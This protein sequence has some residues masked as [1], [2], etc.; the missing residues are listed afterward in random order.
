MTDHDETNQMAEDLALAARR[1]TSA[2]TS[3]RDLS[4]AVERATQSISRVGVCFVTKRTLDAIVEL[5]RLRTLRTQ[6]KLKGRPG[7]KQLTLRRARR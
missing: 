3:I 4:I 5:Q 6:L 7:W 1:V 2:M